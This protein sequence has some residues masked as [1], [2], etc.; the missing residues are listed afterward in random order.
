MPGGPQHGEASRCRDRVMVGLIR[1]AEPDVRAA[2][3]HLGRHG[4]PSPVA[5]FGDDGG[6]LGVVF[7]V[8]DVDL[9]VSVA[10]SRGELLG[11]CHVLGTQ[12]DGLAGEVNGLYLVDDGRELVFHGG[13]D[14]V[15]LIESA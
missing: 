8:E 7:R 11:F 13:V 10:Q 14:A 6:L 4:D 5:G 3:G 12:Q 9:D 15:G 1:P 2:S